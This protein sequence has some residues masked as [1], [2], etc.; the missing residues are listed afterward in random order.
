[1]TK[2]KT[3]SGAMVQ[4]LALHTVDRSD[5]LGGIDSNPRG[6]VFEV[7]ESELERLERCG[8]AR[9]ATKEEIKEA[10]N[11]TLSVIEPVAH[12]NYADVDREANIAAAANGEVAEYE[13]ETTTGKK[14]GK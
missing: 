8:A 2:E 9:K 10:K 14:A 3:E 11:G 7:D 4:V 5:D 1:M 6:S 12:R 13:G